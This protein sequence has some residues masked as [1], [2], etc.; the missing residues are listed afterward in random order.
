MKI[1]S[2]F[3]TLILFFNIAT[4]DELQIPF[5][6]FPKE[7]QAKFL[8]YNLKLDLDGNERTKDSWGFLE[9]K[10]SNYIIFTYRS[11]TQDELVLI[12]KIAGEVAK[13]Q[14]QP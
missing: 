12:M 6:C 2:L 11:V 9:N 1:I 8:K 3:I 5:S 13:S 14:S 4:A 7:I 10:G